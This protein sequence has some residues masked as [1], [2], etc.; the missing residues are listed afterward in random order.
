MTGA[1]SGI[2]RASALVLAKAGCSL[3]VTDIKAHELEETASAVS[4]L[5]AKVI[6]V[7]LDVTDTAAVQ[8]ASKETIAEYGRVDIVFSNA[9]I[10][11]QVPFL[12]I[13]D[14]Q[15]DEMFNVHV[16]GTYHCYQAFLPGMIERGWGR[17]ICTSSMGAL[18]GGVGLVHYCAAKAGLAGL[19]VSMASELARTGVTVNAVAPGVID[20]PMVR[21]SSDN[22]INKIERMIPQ[23]RL[24]IPDDIAYAV[25]YLASEQ[26]GFVTGQ[27]LSPNGGSYTKWC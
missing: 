27:V 1:A 13:T 5:G 24:G 19:T 7:A 3:V 14:C 9:G 11:R 15:W 6:P 12:E 20:T 21:Q 22:L 25:A 18:T 10:G 26:A 4:D 8:M 2:G 23:K 16:T 17:L